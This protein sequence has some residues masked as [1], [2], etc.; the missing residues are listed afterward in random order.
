MQV[1]KNWGQ[2]GTQFMNSSI[3]LHNAGWGKQNQ[4]LSL[5]L[6][7]TL[8]QTLKES[9]NDKIYNF[10][11]TRSIYPCVYATDR[12]LL[13]SS[14][15]PAAVSNAGYEQLNKFC[16][17]FEKAHIKKPQYIC[18]RLRSVYDT[19]TISKETQGINTN[20]GEIVNLYSNHGR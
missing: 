14:Y 13:K 11:P 20:E 17:A 9:I 2:P 3:F 15:I 16:I 8:S 7:L 1:P 19:M 4:C 5:L 6:C 12:Y 10:V 18:Y